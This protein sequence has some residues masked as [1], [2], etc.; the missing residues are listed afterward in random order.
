MNAMNRPMAGPMEFFRQSGNTSSTRSR[1]W[2]SERAR[3][4]RPEMKTMLRALCHAKP[5]P[6]HT[7]NTKRKFSPIPGA[8][9]KG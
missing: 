3:N 6:M 9:A 8:S 2:N 1:I 7:V 4:S 5:M